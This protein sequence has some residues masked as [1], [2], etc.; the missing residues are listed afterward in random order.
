LLT[1]VEQLILEH[2][3]LVDL[4]FVRG[5]LTGAEKRRLLR[6]RR[7]LDWPHPRPAPVPVPTRE[8]TIEPFFRLECLEEDGTVIESVEAQTREQG[9]AAFFEAV[10]L[11]MRLCKTEEPRK[12]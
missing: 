6:I 7:K 8:P 11:L 9:E 5:H 4:R 12:P 10:G 2:G 1:A 3:R